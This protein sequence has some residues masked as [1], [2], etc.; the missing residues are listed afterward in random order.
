MYNEI[1]LDTSFFKKSLKYFYMI[2]LFL[3]QMEKQLLMKIRS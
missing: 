2:N 1:K 3:I